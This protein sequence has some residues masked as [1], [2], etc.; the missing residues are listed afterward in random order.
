MEEK[1][2]AILKSDG[3]LKGGEI[4]EKLGADKKEV[5]KAIKSLIAAGK[6]NSPKRCYYGVV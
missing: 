3:A 5:D 2:L 1:V 6:V 4:A